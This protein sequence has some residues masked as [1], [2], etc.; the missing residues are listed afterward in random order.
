M[1]HEHSINNTT[2]TSF[3]IVLPRQ[4]DLWRSIPPCRHILGHL[5]ELFDTRQAKVRD[6]THRHSQRDQHKHKHS[7]SLLSCTEYT[8]RHEAIFVGEKIAWFLCVSESHRRPPQR[9]IFSTIPQQQ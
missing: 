1:Q 9:A 4:Y 3:A 8:Y 2:R 6:L 5:A 7:L